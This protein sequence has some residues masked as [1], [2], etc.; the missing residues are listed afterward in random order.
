MLAAASAD[1]IP[2]TGCGNCCD[3]RFKLHSLSYGGGQCTYELAMLANG[4]PRMYTSQDARVV[5]AF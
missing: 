3:A 1:Q 2:A 5:R 4:S